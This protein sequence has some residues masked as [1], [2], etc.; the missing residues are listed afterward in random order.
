MGSGAG[1][2]NESVIRA[3]AANTNEGSRIFFIKR[4]K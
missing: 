1:F 3:K 4:E 2:V